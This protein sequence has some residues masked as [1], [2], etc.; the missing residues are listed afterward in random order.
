MASWCELDLTHKMGAKMKQNRRV[1]A[2]V[3]SLLLSVTGD[4]QQNVHLGLA[5]SPNAGHGIT[6][7]YA[8]EPAGVGLRFGYKF[9]FDWKFTDSYAIGS[10]VNV[11]HAGGVITSLH[12]VD[13]VQ[14]ESKEWGIR[15]QYV[16]VPISF[17]MRTKEIGYTT[18]YGQFGVGLGINVRSEVDERRSAAWSRSSSDEAWNAVANEDDRKEPQRLAFE[19]STRLFRPSLIVGLG[20]ERALLGSTAICFGVAYNVGLAN[21]FLN[22][23]IVRTNTSGIPVDGTSN[24]FGTGEVISDPA[25]VS[26]K[27]KTGFLELSV[28]VMF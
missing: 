6:R 9:I 8:H 19:A 7:D 20:G 21:Q 11:F 26:M 17:K 4:A 5:L 24:S 15:N 22:Q 28:G 12:Q 3:V 18:Y 16:E 25:T 27:G 23:S 10:G 13:S 1:L 2:V 14:I